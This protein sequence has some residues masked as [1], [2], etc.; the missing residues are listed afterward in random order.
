MMKSNNRLD[1]VQPNMVLNETF[2]DY[3]LSGA[4]RWGRVDGQDREEDAGEVLHLPEPV[5][6]DGGF[7]FEGGEAQHRGEGRRASSCPTTIPR[8]RTASWSG[9][10][11]TRRRSP[12]PS[13]RRLTP[14]RWGLQPNSLINWLVV[15]SQVVPDSP[16]EPTGEDTRATGGKTDTKA[17]RTP[18]GGHRGHQQAGRRTPTRWGLQPNSFVLTGWLLSPWWYLTAPTVPAGEGSGASK[19]LVKEES[20][21]SAGLDK[22]GSSNSIKLD[23]T[24]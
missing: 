11:T 3:L 23:K 19:T 24:R 12:C 7:I 20:E 2:V 21:P 9:A 14:I 4:A 10:R 16:L 22:V 15:I 6:Q 18:E 5:P 17:G 13:A 8:P 1:E